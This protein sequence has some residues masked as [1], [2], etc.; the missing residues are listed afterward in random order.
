MKQIKSRLMVAVLAVLLM[1]GG[2]GCMGL[3]R[4]TKQGVTEAA[5]SYMSQRYGEEFVYAGPWGTS[6]A[7]ESVKQ[8]LVRPAGQEDGP[9]IL[10]RAAAGEEGYT[11][12]DNYLAVRYAGQMQETL[13]AAAEQAFAEAVVFYQVSYTTLSPDLPADASFEVYSQDE[14]AGI[15]GTVAVAGEGFSP[16]QLDAFGQAVRKTGI[17]AY[18]RLVVLEGAA[19]DSLDLTAVDDAISGKDYSGFYLVDIRRDGVEIRSEEVL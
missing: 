6:Y 13:Q 16:E 9:Q 2:C 3:F 12:R 7:N 14:S 11:F 1:L 5:L 10:V 15:L 18:L 17:Q 4:Q 8:M 19:V